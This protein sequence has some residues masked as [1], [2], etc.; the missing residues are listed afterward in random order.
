MKPTFVVSSNIDALG[1][2]LGKLYIRFKSG[3]TYAY[4]SVPYS[5]FDAL[6]KAESVGKFF[7]RFVRDKYPHHRLDSD[8]FGGQ[9]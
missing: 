1:Y 5:V 3:I 6:E 9:A 4:D 2:E 7:H 8:P